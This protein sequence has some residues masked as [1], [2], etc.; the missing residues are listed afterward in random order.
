VWWSERCRTR[1]VASHVVSRGNNYDSPQTVLCN[2]TQ[3][4]AMGK[5]VTLWMPPTQ[6]AWPKNRIDQ[7]GADEIFSDSAQD[8]SLTLQ[9]ANAKNTSVSYVWIKATTDLH[10]SFNLFLLD[11]AL[12][13]A[14][15]LFATA[16]AFG[17]VGHYAV[18]VEHACN[19]P[20]V[21]SQFVVRKLIGF[22]G[23][24]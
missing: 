8:T 21:L 9:S 20:Q 6:R 17:R 3:L 4:F 15:K 1:V 23:N 24:D 7:K 13:H 18:N 19:V 14:P 2:V 22:R 11:C 16:A 12:N 10:R 5:S